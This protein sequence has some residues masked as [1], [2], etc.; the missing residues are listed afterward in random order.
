MVDFPPQKT[1]RQQPAPAQ[2]QAQQHLPPS[3][4]RQLRFISVDHAGLMDTTGAADTPGAV[5]TPG[6]SAQ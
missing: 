3:V 2:P 5:G 6:P 4:T 1:S